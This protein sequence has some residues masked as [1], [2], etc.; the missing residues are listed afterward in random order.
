TGE[1]GYYMVNG[2]GDVT[3]IT[4]TEGKLINEYTYDIWGKPLEHSETIEQSF[5]Y[6]GEYWDEETNLQY[7]RARWYDPS[8][9]RFI[10]EDTYEGELNNPLSLN[11]YTYVENNPLRY[12]DP[13]GHVKSGDVYLPSSYNKQID[14]YTRLWEE[15]QL[16]KNSL[17]KNQ[18]NYQNE[19]NKI[20][21]M[22]RGYEAQADQIRISYYVTL[23]NPSSGQINAAAAAGYYFGKTVDL[24]AGWTYRKDPA[25][26]STDTEKHI[27]VNGPNGKHWSKN[28]SGS[29]HD[30]KSNSPGS[31]P[32]WVQK[33]LKKRQKWDW[34]IDSGYGSN[35]DDYHFFTILIVLH[36]VV[37]VNQLY[38][39][40]QSLLDQEF[41][42]IK[43]M[44]V[45]Q[46]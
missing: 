15:A 24:G 18:S 38:Q 26:T 6:S 5:R 25:D 13:S 34:K 41:F 31:P 21:A 3:G 9:G 22:Q 28:A 35:V 30:K 23:A 45:I 17:K 39:L 42:I 43:L 44:G 20:T 1:K 12:V 46:I 10:N 27:H 32:N 14:N 36:M 40:Y 7:L 2:H 19:L 29:I 16:K 37:T 33:E 4:D 8:I 11:L